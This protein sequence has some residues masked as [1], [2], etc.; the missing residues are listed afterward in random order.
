MNLTLNEEQKALESSIARV[1]QDRYSFEQR[2]AILTSQQGYSSDLWGQYAELGWLALP[3]SEQDGG[4]GFGAAE[5]MILMEQFGRHL[6]LEPYWSTVLVGG[7]FLSHAQDAVKSEYLPRLLAGDAHCAFAFAEKQSRFNLADVQTVAESVSKGWKL[8]GAKTV[9]LNAPLA[10][11]AIVTART[12]GGEQDEQGV[13]LFAI[14]LKQAKN[15]DQRN[16]RNFD[17]SQAA[18][19]QFDGTE[20]G[21]DHLIGEEGKGLEIVRKILGLALL[22]LGAEAVGAMSVLQADTLEYA[23]TREQFGVPIANFQVLQ[24]RMVDM[25]MELEQSRS[26][27]YMAAVKIDEGDLNQIDYATA[28]LKAQTGKAGRLMSQES[29][30]IHGGMGMTEELRVGHYFKRLM[31]IE[32]T[33]GNTEFY[34][35]RF[36]KLA[37]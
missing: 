6:V 36:A 13:S 7:G 27:L 20:V 28:A 21:Q 30:Q 25:F 9:V 32:S 22:G 1:L 24:H 19:L 8:R 14:P 31:A 34:L 26:L 15:L 23:R 4:L 29:V 11:I 33:L 16:Y 35:K 18:E 2:H 3:F 12:S 5:V 37:A 10:D 17:G